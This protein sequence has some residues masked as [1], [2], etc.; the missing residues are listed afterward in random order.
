[1]EKPNTKISIHKTWQKYKLTM[2]VQEKVSVLERQESL[3]K[4]GGT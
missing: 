3:Y 4:G 1:M 2:R